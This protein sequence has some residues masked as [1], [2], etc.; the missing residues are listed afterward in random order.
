MTSND[1]K[2]TAQEKLDRIL[3]GLSQGC[4]LYVTTYTKCIRITQRHVD[5]WAAAGRPLLKVTGNSLYMA[6]GKGYDCIDFCSIRIV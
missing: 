3:A 6:V 2:T 5:K 4:V 1:T